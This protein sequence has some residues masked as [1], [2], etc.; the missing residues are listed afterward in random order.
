MYLNVTSGWQLHS[1][2][3]NDTV[4]VVYPAMK[5][6]CIVLCCIVLHCIVLRQL[7]NLLPDAACSISDAAQNRR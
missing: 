3:V 4:E 6:H 5:V 2:L 1:C 7:A